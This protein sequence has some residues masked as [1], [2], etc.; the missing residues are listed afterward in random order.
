M[1]VRFVQSHLML[2]NLLNLHEKYSVKL[3][4]DPLKLPKDRAEE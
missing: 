1:R 4:E 3:G 2:L